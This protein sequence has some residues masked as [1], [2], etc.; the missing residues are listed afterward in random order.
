MRET[1]HWTIDLILILATVTFAALCADLRRRVL[2]ET[3]KGAAHPIP[4]VKLKAFDPA[5]ST[6][7]LGPT[8]ASE[9]SFIGKGDGV[10]GGAS[11]PETWILSTLSKSALHLFEFGTCT[12]KTAYLWA[13][14]SAPEARVFTLTLDPETTPTYRAEPGDSRIAR[15]KAIEESRF[16]RLRYTGSDVEGKITQLYG[17]SKAFDETPHLGRCDLIFV[18]G[19][20]AY[21]YVK[22]D[23]EK[24]LRML[25]EGGTI[26]WHDYRGRRG[27]TRGVYDYLNELSRTLP[28]VHLRGT[29]LVAYVS[30]RGEEAAG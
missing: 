29:S 3:G 4:T 14:N 12:G 1:L 18:D 8:P 25:S 10:P 11:D 15:T 22:S 26:L 5:F 16:Q 30:G 27:S 13:R 24:A 17:D 23:S 6:D 2:E 20:H 28:L 21:S 7:D 9:V 19:S